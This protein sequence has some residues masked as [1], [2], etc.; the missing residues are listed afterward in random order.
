MQ[1]IDRLLNL[2]ECIDELLTVRMEYEQVQASTA[3]Q[4]KIVQAN[5]K[6]V[7]AHQ[8]ISLAEKKYNVKNTRS[9]VSSEIG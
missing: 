3:L 5:Q 6:I 7:K 8:K 9:P 4:V 2:V 1:K